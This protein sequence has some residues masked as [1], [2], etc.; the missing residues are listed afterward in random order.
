MSASDAVVAVSVYA[1]GAGTERAVV[2]QG[3]GVAIFTRQAVGCGAV[4]RG[5]DLRAAG[6]AGVV[7]VERITGHAGVVDDAGVYGAERTFSSAGLAGVGGAVVGV[8]AFFV[9]SCRA[10]SRLA[11]VIER[12]VVSVFACAAFI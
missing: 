9:C 5:V 4:G 12:A 8:G 1:T 3:A 10:G 7:G 11:A 2:L 6:L